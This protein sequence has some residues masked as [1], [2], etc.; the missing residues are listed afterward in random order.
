MVSFI[1]LNFGATYTVVPVFCIVIRPFSLGSM[2]D[3]SCCRS[4]NIIT[5]GTY[6]RL[7]LG[8]LCAGSMSYGSI[9]CGTAVVLTYVPVAI[10]IGSP[11]FSKV[12]TELICK[13]CAAYGTELILGTGCC[14]TRNMI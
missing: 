9:G 1:K 3:M 13:F 4:E 8:R 5:Y 14:R 10:C 7:G 2:G 12:M 6:L 11:S